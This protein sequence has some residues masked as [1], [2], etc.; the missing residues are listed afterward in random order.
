MF[1]AAAALFA[2]TSI[3]AGWYHR[4]QAARAEAFFARGGRLA[5][6]DKSREA[7]QAYQNALA[8][9]RNNTR[10]RLAVALELMKL[11][12][13]AEAAIYFHE[14]LRADPASAI[15]NLMLARIAVSN[16]DTDG[17]MEYYHRAVFGYWPPGSEQ[18]RTDAQWELVEFLQKK[19]TRKQVL[20]E[21]LQLEQMPVGVDDR[22]RV[23]GLLV[24]YGAPGRASDIFR[25]ILRQDSRD[26]QAWAGLGEANL[27]QGQYLEARTAFHRAARL[28][29]DDRSIRQRLEVTEAVIDLDPTI[30]GLGQDQRFTRS[31][32]LLRLAISALDE[33]LKGGASVPEPERKLLANARK[34][35]GARPLR[36]AYS[37]ATENNISLAERLWELRASLCASSD[38][39]YE[40]LARVLARLSE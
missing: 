31:Q 27:M 38:S 37:T 32:N 4:A 30:R 8:I 29:P 6:Q 34:A 10:F 16:G 23:A 24:E 3:A 19:G 12:R 18:R 25:D 17:A 7:I 22:K 21:L 15:P 20:A 5:A 13:P 9:D 1:L 11:G 36:S 39:R 26:A 28:N 35:A 33:C 14:L 2:A 40:A